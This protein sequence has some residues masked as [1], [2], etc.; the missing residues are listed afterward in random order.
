MAILND[1]KYGYATEG[2]VMRLSLLRAPT[3]PDAD[4]DMGSHTFSW[5][6]YPHKGTFAESD[7][8]LVAAMFNAPMRSEYEYGLADTV[9]SMPHDVEPLEITRQPI[10]VEGARNVFIA[11]I[12][13]GEDDGEEAFT[14]IVRLYEQYG[15]HAKATLNMYVETFT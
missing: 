10:N 4:C 14:V 11:A 8:P 2:N 12:K 9:R 15:G 6:I 7:V 1:C 3:E 5:G 13:R